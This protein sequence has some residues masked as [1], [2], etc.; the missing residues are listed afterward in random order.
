MDILVVE[1]DS[2]ERA[3]IQRALSPWHDSIRLVETVA[4][5]RTAMADREP[6]LVILDLGLPDADGLEVLK[7]LRRVSDAPVL[8]Y[9]GR[10]DEQDTVALLE[11]GADDYVI[12]PVGDDELRA[13]VRTQLRRN[14]PSRLS[15]PGVLRAADLSIDVARRRVVRGNEDVRL[16]PTEWALLRELIAN[17]GVTVTVA[18]LW[19]RVWSREYGDSGLHVRVQITHLRHKLEAAPADPRLIVTDPGVGYRFELP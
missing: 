11:A 19:E 15:G 1:D 3:R 18:Q 8:V 7:Q 12:K 4:A 6:S 5:A 10:A 17:A 13:R 2:H 16:T 9:S 14:E